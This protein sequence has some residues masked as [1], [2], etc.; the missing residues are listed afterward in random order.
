[1]EEDQRKYG[2]EM[3]K[4]NVGRKQHTYTSRQEIVKE[5]KMKS[6]LLT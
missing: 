4:Y 2:M 6:H 3:A 1:M 5:L